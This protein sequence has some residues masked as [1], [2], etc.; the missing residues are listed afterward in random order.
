MNSILNLVLAAAIQLHYAHS[1]SSTPAT[2][3][4]V[5]PPDVYHCPF[6]VQANLAADLSAINI[7][8]SPKTPTH[9]V[10]QDKVQCYVRLVLSYEP[11]ANVA[12]VKQIDYKGPTS[13]DLLGEIETKTVWDGLTGP[14]RL[15]EW[16]AMLLLIQMRR[17]TT[18]RP[19]SRAMLPSALRS[20]TEQHTQAA[21]LHLTRSQACRSMCR[22]RSRESSWTAS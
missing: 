4:L 11:E 16:F 6:D 8:Y 18:T 19:T 14:V 15:R 7:H 2:W 3:S 22:R 12:A 1:Q 21:A 13:G 20:Q 17:Q 10:D 5:K 9:A